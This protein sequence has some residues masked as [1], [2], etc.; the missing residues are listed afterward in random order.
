MVAQTV[1][2]VGPYALTKRRPLRLHA[3]AICGEHAS[4]ALIAVFNDGKSSLGRSAQTDGGNVTVVILCVRSRLSNGSTGSSD[5][6]FAIQSVAP[7]SNVLK[8]SEMA[9][10]KLID[11][12]CSTRLSAVT[13]N[14]SRCANARFTTP[15]CWIKTPFGRPVE[16]DV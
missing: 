1:T 6:G 14:A 13:A 11:A 2:S 12:N 4:P 16:P 15:R 5:S 10:S 3:A 9:A 8:I 7:V